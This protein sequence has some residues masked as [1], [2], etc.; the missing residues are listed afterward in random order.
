MKRKYVLSGLA[1]IATLA[2]ASPV[3]A[4]ESLSSLVKKEV[5]KQLGAQTAKKKKSKRGPPGPAGP[6]GP[7]G[8]GGPAGPAGGGLLT[9]RINAMP[10]SGV[11]FGGPS[12]VGNSTATFDNATGLSGTTPLVGSNLLVRLTTALT[13]AQTRGFKLLVNGDPNNGLN[14]TVTSAGDGKSCASTGTASVPAGA[15]IAFQETPTNTPPVD[16]ASFS[17]QLAP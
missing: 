13:S 6:Q 2:I 17:W 3:L 1:L 14:C 15:T 5:A 9:G 4:G 10:S 11:N 8:P 16:G 12:G 7:T